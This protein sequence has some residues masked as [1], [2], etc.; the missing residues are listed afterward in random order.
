MRISDILRKKGST[1]VTVGEGRTVHEA[2][3]ILNKHKIGA[4]VVTGS[5]GGI[6]GIISERDVL[7]MCGEQC[8]ALPNRPTSD[9]DP[10]PAL[11][12]DAMTA[13]V[14][15]GVPEDA[16]T[17]VMATMTKNRIRHLP[18]LEDGELVGIIS[19]G[20]VV[21]AHVEETEFDNRQLKDYIAGLTY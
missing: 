11:V 8:A 6:T 13:D 18:V 3:C 10:C 15:I 17:Y 4:L 19:I 14:I 20:D 5:G 12:K 1:V 16:L 2:I 21:N 7:R 9:E